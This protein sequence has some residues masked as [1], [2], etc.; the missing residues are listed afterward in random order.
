M[1][2]LNIILESISFREPNKAEVSFPS[3]EFEYNE[4]ENE[5][6]IFPKLTVNCL[7]PIMLFPFVVKCTNKEGRNYDLSIGGKTGK[8]FKNK[9]TMDLSVDYGNGNSIVYKFKI[10]DGE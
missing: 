4:T 9:E 3:F 6:S 7:A 1:K 8:L 5:V 2:K 10:L